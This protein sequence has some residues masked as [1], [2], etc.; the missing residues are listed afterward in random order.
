MREMIKLFVIVTLFSAISGG[1]LATVKS[2]TQER[3]EL[4]QLTYVKG[5]A[6]TQILEGCTNNPIEDRFKLNH[7]GS[8]IDFF[9][10]EFDG[11]RNTIAFENYGKGF[12]GNMGVMV[13][14]NTD[15]DQIT[16]IG[17]TT[18]S[19]SPG[20]GS[21]AK[22][23]PAFSRQFKGMSIDSAFRVKA[24]GGDIDAISGA[25]VTSRGVSGAVAEVVEIYKRLK[26]EIL[27]N[28][29]G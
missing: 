11:K 19:E 2:A 3:I 14:I 25:T 4:Q 8:S 5:P 20:I 28:V 27:K 9:I 6:I 22:T 16:G 7:S 24:D 1:L 18:H 13:A 21:R 29:Q 15:T 26:N 10:G 23:D 17:I 12:G